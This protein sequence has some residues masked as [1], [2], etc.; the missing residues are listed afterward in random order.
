MLINTEFGEYKIGKKKHDLTTPVPVY[1]GLT[2]A[3]DYLDVTEKHLIQMTE[4]GMF[5]HVVYQAGKQPFYWVDELDRI[6]K[7]MLFMKDVLMDQ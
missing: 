6:G 7:V 1:Y 3:A 5:E 4:Y 2:E